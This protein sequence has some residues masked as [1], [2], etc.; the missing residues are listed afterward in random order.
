MSLHSERHDCSKRGDQTG[1]QA[2]CECGW[3]GEWRASLGVSLQASTLAHDDYRAHVEEALGA[4]AYYQAPV[5]CSNCASH[6]E[7]GVLVGTRVREATCMRCGVK[8]LVP[9]NDAA[10]S[11]NERMARWR[12]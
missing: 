4:E 1:W 5:A 10:H 9:D 6:H 12:L 11:E 2:S 7:Q 8:A 3:E